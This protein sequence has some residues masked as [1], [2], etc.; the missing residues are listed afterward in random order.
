VVQRPVG[1]QGAS[2]VEIETSAGP[3]LISVRGAT[4]GAELTVTVTEVAVEDADVDTTGFEIDGTIYEVEIEGS[5]RDGATVC[6]PYSGT[7]S[8]TIVHWRDDGTRE[9]LNTSIVGPNACADT[10]SFSPFAVVY[11]ATDRVAGAD[12]AETA[13]AV[14]AATFDPGVPVV[15]VAGRAGVSDA[16]TAGA[17]GAPLLLVQ[18][19]AVPAA[20]SAELA[21]LVPGRVVV[22]GGTDVVSDAV[23][24]Q[25]GATRIAGADRYQT[26]AAIAMDRFPSGVPV[27]YVANGSSTPDALV[28]AAAAARDGG[29]VLLVH[30][31]DVPAASAMALAALRADRVVV[32]GGTAVVSDAMV[33][34]LGATRV[35]GANRYETAAALAGDAREV[36]VARGDDPVDAVV[37]A[38]L[39]Q[40]LLLV[41]PASVPQATEVALDRLSPRTVHV[42]GGTS[43]ISAQTE[44]DVA[45]FMA[46]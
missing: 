38:A 26:A 44:A 43:A 35:A 41:L 18:R 32:V 20:T 22:V 29:A 42:L 21:R 30:G 17:A 4:P 28:A 36:V 9:V 46:E 1:T 16:V 23:V 25:L 10:T 6:F 14:S 12:A 33:S 37:G 27:V 8:P 5:E 24:G 34:S 13:A 39:G 3:V 11:L 31:N 7:D 2:D 15:Y 45:A 40:P 19:D